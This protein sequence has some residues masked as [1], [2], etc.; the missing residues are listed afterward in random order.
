MTDTLTVPFTAGDRV[1]YRNIHNPTHQNNGK[2]GVIVGPSADNPTHNFQV[3]LDD[4]NEIPNAFPENLTKETDVSI[5]SLPEGSRITYLGGADDARFIAIM[6]EKGNLY[7]GVS[8]QGSWRLVYGYETY[9][10]NLTTAA[11]GYNREQGFWYVSETDAAHFR[12]AVTSDIIA[13]PTSLAVGTVVRYVGTHSNLRGTW[14]L[15]RHD[16][17]GSSSYRMLT[18]DDPTSNYPTVGT[19]EWWWHERDTGS[20]FSCADLRLVTPE[21]EVPREPVTLASNALSPDGTFRQFLRPPT[22]EEVEV[23]YLM[24]AAKVAE[25]Q[26]AQLRREVADARRVHQS[27]RQQVWDHVTEEAV[28]RDWCTEGTN[29]HLSALGLDYWDGPEREFAVEVTCTYQTTVY[30]TAA[31]DDQASE[32]VTQDIDSYVEFST[33]RHNWD[34]VTVDDINEQ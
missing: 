11:H 34:D 31:S 13:D 12:P 2:Q 27:F 20:T 7:R 16:T 14:E 19:S 23:A 5:L 21:T 1:T 10:G 22:D 17:D 8:D 26:V 3:R 30:V 6:A 9:P 18:K 33:R 15:V 29:R 25:E 28:K 24:Q 32:M 4:G